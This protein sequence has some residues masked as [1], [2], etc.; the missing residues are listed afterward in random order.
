MCIAE[1]ESAQHGSTKIDQNLIKQELYTSE[2]VVNPNDLLWVVT[3]MK[4]KNE[5]AVIVARMGRKYSWRWQP[6]G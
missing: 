2:K 4:K 5:I 3:A 6:Q 1:D